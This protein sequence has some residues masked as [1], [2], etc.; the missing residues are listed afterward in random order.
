MNTKNT[1]LYRASRPQV[2]IKVVGYINLIGRNRAECKKGAIRVYKTKGARTLAV[3]IA[4]LKQAAQRAKAF[5]ASFLKSARLES[6]VNDARKAMQ[7]GYKQ[8]LTHAEKFTLY[9]DFCKAV[10]SLRTFKYSL[11]SSLR[12]NLF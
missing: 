12:V 9:V 7:Q 6:A 1:S 3:K 5:A 2:K 8:F 11:P 4:K 10:N